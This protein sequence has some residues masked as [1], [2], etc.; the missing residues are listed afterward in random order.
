MQTVVQGTGSSVCLSPNQLHILQVF[1]QHIFIYTSL[2]LLYVWYINPIYDY[3]VSLRK[4]IYGTR[5]LV[6][7]F[8]ILYELWEFLYNRLPVYEVLC[9]NHSSFLL[10]SGDEDMAT[11][12]QCSRTN[13]QRRS[14]FQ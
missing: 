5:Q 12:G 8:E 9:T 6:L 14:I 1:N 10:S 2:I 4:P 13:K 3:Y 7:L 11:C